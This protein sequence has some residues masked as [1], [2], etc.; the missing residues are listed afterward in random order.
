LDER[1]VRFTGSVGQAQKN[2]GTPIMAFGGKFYSNTADPVIPARLA[3]VIAAIAG[4][5]NFTR[6]VPGIPLPRQAGGVRLYNRGPGS[7]PQ[8][9]INGG[10]DT[11]G[12]ADV[13]TFYDEN[14]L[15]ASATGTGD[16]LGIVGAS[17]FLATAVTTFNATYSL[18]AES[19][20]TVLADTTNPGFNSAESEA[21]LDLE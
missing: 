11:F 13:R 16:C 3:G 20:T 1:R 12:P 15:L 5:D 4:L 21:L 19:I 7:Q 8:V 14:T 10:T 2:F 18:P 9:I 6:T 17:N